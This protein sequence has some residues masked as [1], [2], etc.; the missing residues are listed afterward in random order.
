MF[1]SPTLTLDLRVAQLGC[2]SIKSN[3]IKSNQIKSNQ[4]KSNQIRRIK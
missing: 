4:I 3:Q 2:F 1:L